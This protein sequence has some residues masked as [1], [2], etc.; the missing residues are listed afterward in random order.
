M[1]TSMENAFSVKGKNVLITGGGRGLGKGISVAMAQ[2][3]ANVAIMARGEKAAQ[4][5]IKEI[6]EYGGT[7]RFYYGDVTDIEGARSVVDKV[8]KDYGKIDVLVNNAGITRFFNVLDMD[9]SL[10]DWFDV[11]NVNLNGTFIMSHL[12]GKKMKESGGGRI[13]NISSNASRIVNLPQRMCSYSASK[14]AIDRLTKCLAHEWAPYNIRVNAI[15]PGYTD[16]DLTPVEGPELEAYMKYWMDSTPTGRF[17]KPI[18]VGALAVFL[19]SEASEQM[20]GTICTIDGGYM[21]AR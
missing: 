19:A 17:N 16:S 2:C 21:L 4:E 9:E 15:A 12:V 14:A 3:G 8:V 11:L 1:I 20:T 7:H 18:E 6:S 10:K 13:I 5:T